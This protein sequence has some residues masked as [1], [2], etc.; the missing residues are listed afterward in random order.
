MAE[1]ESPFLD[2]KLSKKGSEAGK[3]DSDM[4]VSEERQKSFIELQK[5]NEAIRDFF[6]QINSESSWSSKLPP[7][8]ILKAYNDAFENGGS[9]VFQE[10]QKILDHKIAIEKLSV[11]KNLR[12][13]RFGQVYGFV[14]AVS[15]LIASFVLILLGFGIYGTI[16]GSVN[17]I[18][19]VTIFVLNKNQ[20]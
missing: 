15:F 9:L 8:S 12:Q 14:V 1:N 13:R 16:I 7:P 4:I 20:K 17:L 11:D 2:D 3:T 5:N 19:L 10:I 6:S 18:S